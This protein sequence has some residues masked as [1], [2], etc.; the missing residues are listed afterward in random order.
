[1]SHL[2]FNVYNNPNQNEITQTSQL[3]F[4]MTNNQL[5]NNSYELLALSTVLRSQPQFVV[6]PFCHSVCPTRTEKKLSFINTL[7]CV[8]IPQLWIAHQLLK[9]KDLNCYDSQH[10]CLKCNANLGNYSAC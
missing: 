2:N 1:M 9:D 7:F 10:Y 5:Q 8:L 3:Q 4:E 6:C